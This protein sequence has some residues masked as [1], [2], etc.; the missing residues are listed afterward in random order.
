[1]GSFL[2]RLETDEDGRRTGT[3]T[4]VQTGEQSAFGAFPELASILER[5]AGP[6]GAPGST[7]EDSP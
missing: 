3:V 7:E 4:P 2:I 1:M 5:W 6:A